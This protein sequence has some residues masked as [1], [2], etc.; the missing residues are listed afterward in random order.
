[1]ADR[2]PATAKRGNEGTRRRTQ[3][4][5]GHSQSL[6]RG[7]RVL[8][9]LAGA[10]HGVSLSDLSQMVGLAPSTTHRLLKSLEHLQFVQQDGDLGLWQVGVK[11]FSV[12]NA[13]IAVRDFVAESRP[14]LLRLM[15][16]T[17]ETAN[18]AVQDD[19]YAVFLTQVESEWMMRMIVRL[20][21]RAP[22]HASGVGKALL[23]CMSDREVE[24][25]LQRRGLPRLTANTL[26]TP[27]RLRKDLARIRERGYACDYEEHAVGLHC[28]AA[29][30]HN[31]AGAAIAAIS[32]SGPKARVTESAMPE[33][34][35][36]V[37]RTAR[38]ITE[39]IGGRTPNQT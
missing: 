1:M 17:G 25:I 13:F 4:S 2:Q 33:L 24:H 15:E 18:L 7:L 12:G 26:D 34:G 27:T 8:E 23:A 30:L 11:A 32:V 16:Q 28:V 31:E 22:L 5:G 6:T 36:L 14:F 9:A 20:G 3:T 10:G 39:K 35:G 21:S 38:E 19:G 29:T 37:A